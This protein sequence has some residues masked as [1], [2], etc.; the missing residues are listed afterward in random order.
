MRWGLGWR[1]L[2]ALWNGLFHSSTQF[3][4]QTQRSEQWNRGAYLVDGL[5]HCG[6]CHTPRNGLG[7]E[8][9][10]DAYM[11]GAMVDGWQAPAL[12]RLNPAPVAW[13][14]NEFFRYLRHGHTHHHGIAAGP[15]GLVVRNLAAVS[16]EDIRAMAV[17]LASLQTSPVLDETQIT[18]RSQEVVLAAANQ[19]PLPDA[20]QRLFQGSCGACHHDGDG[21]Q[22]L[23]VNRPLALNT[24]VHS[25]RPDNLLRVVLEGIQAPASKDI[26]FMP[27]F[28]NTLSDKQL[29]MLVNGMRARYAPDKPTWPNTAQT[30]AAM[31]KP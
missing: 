11:Q 3:Q 13:D 19:A 12:D 1:P 22:L 16:D 31:R 29:V 30:L 10:A 4:T 2:M 8:R 27:A 28:A 15:M 6:A 5:G 23:G 25:D 17:Y 26:G 14:E 7:A 24:N 18:Q 9:H 21:P 20:A